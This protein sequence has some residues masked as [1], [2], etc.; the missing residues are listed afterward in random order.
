MRSSLPLYAVYQ[1]LKLVVRLLLALYY[2]FTRVTGRRHLRLK[3]PTFVAVNHPNTLIDALQGA[4]RVDSQVFFL[5]NAGLFNGRLAHWFF[6]TFFC[7]PV[8]RPEDTGGRPIDNTVTFDRVTQHLAQ[9]GHLLIAPEGGSLLERR[10]RP[11]KTG[12]ARMALSAEAKHDFSLDVR[13]LPIGLNYEHPERFGASLFVNVGEP[14]RAAEFRDLYQ[15]DTREAA[16]AMTDRFEERLRDLIIDTRDEEEDQLLRRLETLLQSSRP[17]NP[18]RHFY[19]THNLLKTLRRS[20]TDEP[21]A[22]AHRK[23]DVTAYFQTL[24]SLH[25]TDP[26]AAEAMTRSRV[27]LALPL[28]GLILGFPLFLYGLIN[29]A[30]PYFPPRRLTHWLGRAKDLYIGYFATAKMMIGLLTFPL[31]YG[32]QIALVN[33][34]LAWPY[35]LIYAVSLIPAGY[36]AHSYPRM[37]RQVAARRRWRRLPGEQA[38]GLLA[39]RRRLWTWLE[40]HGDT[41]ARQQGNKETFNP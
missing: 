2:P 7:L 3:G 37:A 34:F 15:S 16:R 14:L 33:R 29:N 32:L 38:D 40:Q 19:R 39:Q 28:L 4:A 12:A 17:A 25:L 6:S 24:H 11:L 5:A 8:E 35:V 20:E 41:E 13:I 9:G 21:V 31:F 10:L 36:F 1:F 27:A 18:Q 26:V 22:Y 23:E 30:L